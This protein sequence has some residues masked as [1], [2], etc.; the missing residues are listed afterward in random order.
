M[1]RKKPHKF[2]SFTVCYVWSSFNN[3]ILPVTAN[4]CILISASR[5]VFLITVYEHDTWLLVFGIVLHFPSG[6]VELYRRIFQ[7]VHTQVCKPKQY[8]DTSNLM[9]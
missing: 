8:N 9:E 1:R 4:K 7:P 6:T 5:Y 2:N 3:N